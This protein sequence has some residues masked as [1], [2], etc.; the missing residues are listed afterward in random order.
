M[1]P[2][3][4]NAVVAAVLV[5]A[6]GPLAGCAAPEGV[7]TGIVR[8]SGGFSGTMNR[9]PMP[10]ATVYMKD[11]QGKVISVTSDS[12]ARYSLSLPPGQY[13]LMCYGHPAITVTAG[14]TL[15]LDCDTEVV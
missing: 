8:G 13:T 5:A 12:E 1:Q 14:V 15:M 4:V 6:V 7:V 2:R 11:S 3:L 10:G 9:E